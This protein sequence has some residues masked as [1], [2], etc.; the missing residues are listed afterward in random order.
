MLSRFK[1]LYR[2]YVAGHIGIEEFKE[3]RDS[4]DNVSD[5]CLWDAMLE[6]AEGNGFVSMSDEMK[7]TV[8]NRL[9]RSLMRLR[10]RFYFRYAA[11]AVIAVMLITAVITV[12]LGT[13]A[14][15]TQEFTAYIPAGSR[16]ELTLPDRTKVQL[17]SASELTFGW[18]KEGERTVHLQGEAYF[19]VAKDREHT[20]RVMVSDVEIEVHG[21]AFNVN[22]YDDQSIAVTLERGKVSLGGNAL[23]GQ[24][25]FMQP[26]QKAIYSRSDSSVIITKADV[27]AE[28]GWIRG[29]LVFKQKK[30]SDVLAM[31]ERH[32]GV[33]I[34]MQSDSLADDILTGTFSNEDL[35]DVLTTLSDVYN[36]KY[37]IRKKYILIY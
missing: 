8:K 20:F 12:A 14:V 2:K 4:I 28:T 34:I 33:D 6:N 18:D 31:I 9:R 17:N 36:F 35:T 19:D 15:L 11:A 23:K 7:Q 24:R 10:F 37:T 22:A 3:L 25:Y 5:D 21:T 26:G 1:Q 16:T 32:Y 13:H 30:L 29:D 27:G